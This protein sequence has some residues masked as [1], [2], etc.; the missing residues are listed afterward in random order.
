[1]K[2]T[3]GQGDWFL[4]FVGL[5]FVVLYCLSINHIFVLDSG[6]IA[7]Y[8][9]VG[10]FFALS[11]VFIA[12]AEFFSVQWGNRFSGVFKFLSVLSLFLASLCFVVLQPLYFIRHSD[13]TLVGDSATLLSLGII[14]ISIILK[15]RIVVV[16]GKVSHLEVTDSFVLP[17]GKDKYKRT[18]Q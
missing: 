16:E 1:M 11:D 10:M 12:F 13:L 6:L 3:F 7:I 5:G 2:K 18:E 4:L 15:N 8:S 17:H 14:F 9:I